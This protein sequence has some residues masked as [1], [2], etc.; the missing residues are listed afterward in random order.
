MAAT[1]VGRMEP[2]DPANESIVV[3]LERMQ[4]YF[5]ANRI[6]AKKQVPVF[7]N[8]IGRE[9]Y[10]LLRNLSAP[11][12]PSQKSLKQLWR[13]WRGISSPRRLLLQLV[14]NF[15]S[16]S[17]SLERQSPCFWLNCERWLFHVSLAIALDESLRDS[18]DCGLANEAHQKRLLSE[19]EL[20]LDKAL[21]IAQ[22]LEMAEDNTCTLKGTKPAIR[23]LSKSAA[24]PK[25]P[26]QRKE[27]QATQEPQSRE[28]YR[29]GNTDHLASSCHFASYVCR[30]KCHKKGHLA[31]VCCSKVTG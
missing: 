10:G 23:Q 18:L 20:S 21:L 9:N 15:I 31:C 12:K 13:S 14:F 26:V 30:R 7:L 5:E 17:N 27:S 24:Q 25:V 16:A 1:S 28:C 29:C 3:Y 2:F 8:I 11:E 22:R 6:K 19:G 4:L